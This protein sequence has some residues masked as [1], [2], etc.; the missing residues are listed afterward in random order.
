MDAVL[1]SRIQFGLAAGVHFLF[2]PL[3]SI[4]ALVGMPLVLYYT[5]YAYRALRK[6]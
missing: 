1:L 5:G 4:I 2:P 6:A 3:T